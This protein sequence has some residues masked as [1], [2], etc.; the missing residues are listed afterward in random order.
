MHDTV[1]S[2][3]LEKARGRDENHKRI[4]QLVDPLIQRAPAR[5]RGDRPA[6]NR[7]TDAGGALERVRHES[8]VVAQEAQALDRVVLAAADDGGAD[9]ARD[10]DEE[11]VELLER[12]GLF[13]VWAPEMVSSLFVAK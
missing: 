11:H 9:D 8:A 10:R 6:R 5:T 3:Y 7:T 13:G 2:T 12:S 4:R 1:K